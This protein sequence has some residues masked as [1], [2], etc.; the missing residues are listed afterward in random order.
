MHQLPPEEGSFQELLNVQEAAQLLRVGRNQVYA[1]ARAN[2]IPCV[3]LG[4]RYRFPRRAL[5]RWIDA[6]IEQP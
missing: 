1:W 4:Q 6:Q 2:F 3:R 5:L